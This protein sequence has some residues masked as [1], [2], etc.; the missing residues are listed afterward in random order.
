MLPSIQSRP[1]ILLLCCLGL[2]LPLSFLLLSSSPSSPPSAPPSPPDRFIDTSLSSPSNSNDY[3]VVVTPLDNDPFVVDPR[4]HNLARTKHGY[5]GVIVSVARD[6]TETLAWCGRLKVVLEALP[7]VDV[8]VF[9]A[10]NE[11]FSAAFDQH[12]AIQKH[13]KVKFEKISLA[14]PPTI[15]R[16]K[17]DFNGRYHRAAYRGIMRFY[18]GLFVHHPALREYDYWWRLDQ[19]TFS[20]ANPLTFDPF[21]FMYRKGKVYGCPHLL[22]TFDLPAYAGGLWPHVKQQ[23][24]QRNYRVP[25][26][27]TDTFFWKQNELNACSEEEQKLNLCKDY[28]LRTCNCHFEFGD[29]HFFRSAKWLFDIIDDEG[30]AY[31]YEPYT[32][33]KTRKL[34][35]HTTKA[36]I[37]AVL[38]GDASCWWD[39]SDG[40]EFFG[41]EHDGNMESVVSQ[42]GPGGAAAG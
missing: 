2:L 18:G 37:L 27:T 22:T 33:L 11:P 24:L 40:N 42:H 19:D 32:P 13:C 25:S 28:N 41:F 38:C 6:K 36:L 20:Y 9:V 1:K 5:K 29:L 30:R 14:P 21:E 26:D 31:Y 7:Q 39:A 3:V 10:D 4:F 15:D 16:S 35:D 12:A 8:V 23:F 17:V 34:G